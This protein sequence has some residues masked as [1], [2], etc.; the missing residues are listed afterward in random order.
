[1]YRFLFIPCRKY[2]IAPP[3]YCVAA[4]LRSRT[5]TKE[6]AHWKVRILFVLA[7]SGREND[8]RR[9]IAVICLMVTVN[10]RDSTRH[11]G[12]H[13]VLAHVDRL[14][15]RIWM[16]SDFVVS[17]GDKLASADCFHG[18]ECLLTRTSATP[19]ARPHFVARRLVLA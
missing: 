9:V 1:M 17:T 3:P 16:W 13:R 5:C 10:P 11:F 12:N 4:P 14:F 18:S 15:I 2:R 7:F 6:S 19:P 8:V